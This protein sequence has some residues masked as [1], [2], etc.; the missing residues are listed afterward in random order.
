MTHGGARTS[1]LLVEVAELRQRPGNRQPV[2]T[3]ATLDELGTTSARVRDGR[4]A[5]E[6]VLESL[7]EGVMA[8]GDVTFAWTGE[9]SRC[10]KPVSGDA[11]ARLRELF[12]EEPEEGETYRL[13]IDR[14]DLEPAVRETVMLEL[15]LQPLCRPDCKGLCAQCGA[16]LNDGDCGC[17]VQTGDPRW[18][19]LDD[20]DFD[21]DA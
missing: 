21:D 7:P 19:A 17:E 3:A 6:L 13:D 14:L 18:A 11:A 20:L 2:A 1:P 15:P 9:C 16:D 5:V 10:L 8:A 12:E 4:V